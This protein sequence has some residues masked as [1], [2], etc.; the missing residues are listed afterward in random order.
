MTRMDLELSGEYLIDSHCHLQMEALAGDLD[1]VLQRAG[2]SGI[3]FVIV[4]GSDRKENQKGLA[5]AGTYPQ[6]YAACGIHPHDASAFDEALASE[7][8]EWLAHPKAVAVGETGLDYHY[9]HS[10]RDVQ[11]SVFERHLDI[12]EER[13]L[14]VVIHSREAEADTLDILRSRK[15]RLRGVLHCF[16]GGPQ[17][18][19]QVLDVGFYISIAGPVTYRKAEELRQV[20]RETPIERL[21]IETDAPYLAPVPHRGKRNEPAY[22]VHTAQ[23]VAAIKGLHPGDVA[24]VTSLNARKLF[25]IADPAETTPVA[26]RIRDS[27]YINITNR[28]T[29]QCCFCV[30]QRDP[31]VKGH[32]LKLEHEPSAEEIISAIGDPSPYREVVFC[33]YGEPLLRL[34]VVLEVA[35]WLKKRHCRV[36]VNTNGQASL[37]HKRDV[38]GSLDGLVDE[39]SI[40]LNAH[41]RAEYDRICSPENPG[42]WEAV[43]EFIRRARDSS[44]AVSVT[45]VAMPG[46]DIEGCRNLARQIGVSFRVRAYNDLG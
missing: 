21:L 4:P 39:Y 33:G 32:N 18:A 40:S 14:P 45:A 30:R 26:Y 31:Y 23:Q 19:R 36:R 15:G 37:L 20:V 35:R 34:D 43:L 5:L 24:R 28:C 22:L 38:V 46:V 44:A 29:N 7:L 42:A 12:A 27:L 41:D 6:L 1:E 25:R 2:E 17:M 11:L 9:M 8:M 13:K 10:P 3:R 16:S